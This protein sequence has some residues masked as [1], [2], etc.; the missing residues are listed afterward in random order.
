ME[1]WARFIALDLAGI[2][3]GYGWVFPK[4]DHLN[5]GVGG[6]KQSDR[7]C[8]SGSRGSARYYGFDESRL[9][10]L[11]GYQL[12]LRRDAASHERCRDTR[13]RRGGARRP[14]V[15]RGHLGGVR[16]RPARGGRSTP[17]PLAGC[18]ADL[19]GYERALDATMREEIL[20]SRRL[21]AIFQR[22]PA[23]S[24]LMLKYNRTFWRYMT[25]IIRG[26]IAYPELPRKLGPVRHVLNRWGDSEIAHHE[27]RMQAP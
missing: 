9:F 18:A 20:A 3:G 23:F 1:D 12:P 15:G 10:G 13:R 27:R 2:P 21:M 17:L 26:D 14:A 8:E 16:Q 6:W 5:I 22:L 25:E 4:G 7:R 11:R 19:R 24:V